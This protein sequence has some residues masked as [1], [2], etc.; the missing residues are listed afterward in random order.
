MD[1]ETFYE[2]EIAREEERKKAYWRR[3]ESYECPN[4]ALECLYEEMNANE[5]D[6]IYELANEEYEQ[7]LE[8]EKQG[9]FFG[10]DVFTEN[11]RFEYLDIQYKDN[12]DLIPKLN[13]IQAVIL[14]YAS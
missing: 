7:F 3:V 1:P 6:L 13:A 4:A 12:T 10:E 2:M 5:E 11:E 8:E 9:Y 14:S